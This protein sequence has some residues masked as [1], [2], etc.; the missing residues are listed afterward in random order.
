ME[1]ELG[2][3]KVVLRAGRNYIDILRKVGGDRGAIK[4][5]RT[6]RKILIKK[7][8]ARILKILQ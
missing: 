3:I 1:K 7:M 2:E 8:T 5:K 6:F 4:K